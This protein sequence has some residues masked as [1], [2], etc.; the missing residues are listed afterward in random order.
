M[1]TAGAPRYR[2][3]IRVRQHRLATLVL[4]IVAIGCAKDRVASEKD[5]SKDSAPDAQVGDKDAS[6]ARTSDD[7]GADSGASHGGDA[8]LARDPE[9]DLNGIWIA[10]LTTFSRD[11]VFSATQT[12]SN[13][14]YYEV[15]QSG[16]DFTV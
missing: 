7:A 15:G 16:V 5:G 3:A 8:G 6:H 10:R 13:W 14:F 9:C 12:A 1:E 4:M 2:P 11:T